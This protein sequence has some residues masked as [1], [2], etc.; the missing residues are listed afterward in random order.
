MRQ[1]GVCYS[2]RKGIPPIR[3]PTT[4]K[5][6]FN[7]TKHFMKLFKFFFYSFFFLF[8]YI[9]ILFFSFLQLFKSEMRMR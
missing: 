5:G 8:L 3:D 6:K 2:P 1:E 9:Y 7:L 4:G